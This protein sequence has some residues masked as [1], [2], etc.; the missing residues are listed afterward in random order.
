MS[1]VINNKKRFGI[2]A[3]GIIAAIML[4]IA[5]IFWVWKKVHLSKLGNPDQ[6]MSLGAAA[7]IGQVSTHKLMIAIE[8][9]KCPTD[10]ENTCYQ[11]GDIVLIM[12]GDHEFST[13]EKEGFLIVKMDMTDKQAELMTLSL[14]K[15]TGQDKETGAPKTDTL[16]RRKF[17]V[18]LDKLGIAADDQ[19]GQEITDKTFKW[20]EVV[21]EK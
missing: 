2:F 18:Q 12:A 1:I 8:N 14:E 20:D 4:I 19:K 15:V 7:K 5:G 10:Q 16:K 3:V 17:M 9:P 11:R 21:K 6:T 13:A